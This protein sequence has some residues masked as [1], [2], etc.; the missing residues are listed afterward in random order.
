MSTSGG[1]ARTFTTPSAGYRDATLTRGCAAMIAGLYIRQSLGE[2]GVA[3][4]TAIDVLLRYLDT[5]LP[6]EE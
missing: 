1:C 5:S 2:G 3:P 4:E 6:Q